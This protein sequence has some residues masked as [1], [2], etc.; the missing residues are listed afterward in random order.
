MEQT[1]KFTRLGHCTD[2][3][4][5]QTLQ[6]NFT[7]NARSR[8]KQ[9]HVDTTKRGNNEK[10]DNKSKYLL[11]VTDSCRGLYIGGFVVANHWLFI[12]S[13][14]LDNSNPFSSFSWGFRNKRWLWSQVW[15][16]SF[17]FYCLSDACD[18][19]LL[20]SSATTTKYVFRFVFSSS[21]TCNSSTIVVHW[22]RC[23]EH[24]SCYGILIQLLP[25]H[26]WL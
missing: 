4:Y 21:T 7:A 13:L 15:I 8:K 23:W 2:A 20:V 17:L 10:D 6:Q 9:Q 24:A 5:P 12:V 22:Y 18:F 3:K 26:S 14:L 25:F 1:Q 19:L 16:V 11:L